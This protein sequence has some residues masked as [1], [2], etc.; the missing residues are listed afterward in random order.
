MWDAIKSANRNQQPCYYTH[1]PLENACAEAERLLTKDP[2]QAVIWFAEYMR[3][4]SK[5]AAEQARWL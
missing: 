4:E 2:W 3:A 5:R 1:T